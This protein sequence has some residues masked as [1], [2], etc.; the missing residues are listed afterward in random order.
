M[1]ELRVA[2]FNIRNG[3]ALDGLVR[4]WPFRRRAVVAAIA[5]LD[6]DVVGLQEVYRFQLRS[7]LRGLPR[8]ASVGEGRSVRRRGEHVP[9]L[10]DRGRVRVVEQ[11]TRW[12]GDEP[13]RPGTRLPGA[14]FPR[15]ATLAVLEVGGTRLQVV[16]THLDARSPQHR[17]RSVEQLVSWLD[18]TVP[19]VVLGDLNA[20]PDAPEL[21][22]LLDAG[23]REA[24]PADAGGTNHDFTGR[25]DG[26][27]LDHV[28]VSPEVEVLAAEIAHPGRG[29]RLPSDH[30]PV[31]A[32]L[33]V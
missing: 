29:G 22:P 23:L 6:A 5:A 7:L 13:D 21:R 19:R 33:R 3:R 31:V 1:T 9:L 2:T 12:F 28:L 18:P 32:D 30:W 17:A 27:R 24:L 4:S 16:G 14:R 26:A 11:T 15:I 10:V 8:C 20:G 25:T